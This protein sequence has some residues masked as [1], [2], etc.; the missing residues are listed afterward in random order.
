[1]K[2]KKYI[3][4]AVVLFSN[5]RAT[6]VALAV[7]K[8]NGKVNVRLHACGKDGEISDP[9]EIT[10]SQIDKARELADY[11]DL[12][13]RDIKKIKDT[14]MARWFSLPQLEET[15]HIGFQKDDNGFL[16]SYMG[17]RC[18]DIHGNKLVKDEFVSL[19]KCRGN[20][21]DVVDP[22]NHY[23]KKNIKR[24]IVMAHALSGAVC[25]LLG[26]NII[27]SVVGESSKGK[28]TALKMGASFFA[29]PDYE[30]TFLKWSSTQNA[31]VRQMSDLSGVNVLIDDTQLSRIKTF[32]QIIY[33][34]ESGQSIDRLVRGNE[35]C[36]RSY[37]S[38]SIGITAE[39]SVLDSINALGAVARLIEMPVRK[40]D[41][42][43]DVVE[44]AEIKNLYAD[45]YGSVGA[46]FVRFL[47]TCYGQ[48]TISRLVKDEGQRSCQVYAERVGDNTL[49]KRHLDNDIAVMIT[50]AKLANQCLG[51]HFHVPLLRSA[52][53]GLCEENYR[54]F[55]ENTFEFLVAHTVYKDIL[56]TGRRLYPQN[57]RDG[58][59]VIPSELMKGL[60]AKYSA[61]LKV[62]SARIKAELAQN[63]MLS[64]KDGTYCWNHTI[65]G[66]TVTGYELIIT[67]SEDDQN[68]K[69]HI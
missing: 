16:T 4:L 68:E 64:E 43:D 57:E 12:D 28:T 8:K 45:H 21:A 25:G 32:E 56:G 49:L 14:L 17:S 44:V 63:G 37:W 62:K 59:I 22:L 50:T 30:T 47:L 26:K 10:R 40:D 41:L 46:T 51:F 5:E 11:A 18:Y 19:P 35:L 61:Q 53:L 13:R 9:V 52:M 39:H 15:E 60:L 29:Q 67:N 48:K 31:L 2:N 3:N 65:D 34:F 20:I 55:S 24:E 38:V 54:T 42:F 6:V 1:M 58:R 33:S 23:M 7:K 66:S 69:G 27:L 36:K